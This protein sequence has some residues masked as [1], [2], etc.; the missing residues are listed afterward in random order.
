VIDIAAEDISANTIPTSFVYSDAGD[1]QQT[2]K[3]DAAANVIYNGKLLTARAA[4]DFK[5]KTGSVRLIDSDGNGGYETL[6]IK[7]Y[8]NYVVDGVVANDGVIRTMYN[9]GTFTFT[10]DDTV[11]PTVFYKDGYE[12]DIDSI[13]KWN[14]ISVL[15]SKNNVGAKLC[16]VYISETRIDGQITETADEGGRLSAVLDNGISYKTEKELE[17]REGGNLNKEIGR[18]YAFYLDIFGDIAAYDSDLASANNYGYLISAALNK[19]VERTAKFKLFT[20]SQKVE[21]IDAADKIKFDG[22]PVTHTGA[23]DKLKIGP[24]GGTVTDEDAVK[25]QLIVYETNSE[26]KI[27]DFKTAVDKSANLGYAASKNE[28]VLSKAYTTTGIRIYK[29]MTSKDIYAVGENTVIFDIPSDL[30]KEK[31]FKTG[32][33]FGTDESVKAPA[34]FYD[35]RG[36]G[37]IGVMV[38]ISSASLGSDYNDPQVVE[39]TVQS[40]DE[41]G[42]PVTKIYF[43][44]GSSAIC[45]AEIEY[46]ISLTAADPGWDDN[47]PDWA[48]WGYGNVRVSDLK[49]GDIIQYMLKDGKIARIQVLLCVDNIGGL[50]YHN[51][52]YTPQNANNGAEA[53]GKSASEVARVVS[54]SDDRKYMVVRTK[55]RSEER[56]ETRQIAGG[57]RRYDIAKGKVVS[58]SAQ[59][60]QEGDIVFLN[61][62][63]LS[64]RMIV[65]YR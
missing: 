12:T 11:S 48:E 6:I 10:V 64:T 30:S 16:E 1:R 28:F 45:D 19:G 53:M 44:G 21:V 3:I 38:I 54:V 26:G 20:L 34:Y 39:K 59:D 17:E 63:W 42:L 47:A 61:H 35:V 9:G 2:V 14:V 55:M 5:P 37:V 13:V 31:N 15:E 52:D 24:P 27:T 36:G 4:D 40:I 65:I 41:D 51:S 18:T 58:S 25:P 22:V 60:I 29:Q 43:S 23:V 32:R 7:D 49:E 33:K 46:D 50:R 62:F 57:V 56:T 8:K